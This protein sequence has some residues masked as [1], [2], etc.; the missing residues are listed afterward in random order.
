MDFLQERP[1]YEPNETKTFDY[2]LRIEQSNDSNKEFHISYMEDTTKFRSK[3]LRPF[4]E[5]EV[6]SHALR[7]LWAN[8][9]YNQ[10]YIS[11]LLNACS[12]EAFLSRAK[13]FV[14]SFD[15]IQDDQLPFGVDLLLRT[16]GQQLCSTELSLLLNVSPTSI[17]S[18]NLPLLEYNPESEE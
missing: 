18:A 3:F 12:K 17:D 8:Y 9:Q 14:R 4:F 5:N 1:N 10:E 11:F 16:L 2:M 13:G 6:L 7:N 15:E